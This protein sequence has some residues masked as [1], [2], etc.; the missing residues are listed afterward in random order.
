[1]EPGGLCPQQA[2]FLMSPLPA[3]KQLWD[4]RDEEQW[5]LELGRTQ[6]AQDF[7]GVLRNGQMVKIREKNLSTWTEAAWTESESPQTS[8][9]NWQEWCASMEGLGSLIMLTVSL[10]LSSS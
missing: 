6:G 8:N 5:T 2:G 1:M 9:E 7:F 3:R 4:A 10:W